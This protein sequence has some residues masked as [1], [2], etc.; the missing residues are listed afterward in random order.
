[1]GAREGTYGHPLDDF[2]K[3]GKMWGAILGTE[4]IPPE[5]VG[6]MMV[7]VKISREVNQPKR[8]N[9]VDGAGYFLTVDRVHE[10][11]ARRGG[12]PCDPE[13]SGG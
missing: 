10:E 12:A 3:T 9:R 7:A 4:P 2:T 6:L 1:M 5:T 8:D 11:R 13:D